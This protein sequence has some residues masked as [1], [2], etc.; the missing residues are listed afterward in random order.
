MDMKK[1]NIIVAILVVINTI[2]IVGIVADHQGLFS[3]N[4]LQLQM[5]NKHTVYI[6][7]GNNSN[8]TEYINKLESKIDSI[9][10]KNN[11]PGYTLFTT[12]GYMIIDEKP[13]KQKTLVYVFDRLTDDEIIPLLNDFKEYDSSLVLFVE[14]SS[15]SAGVYEK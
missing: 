12:E 5:H 7:L 4:D 10:E 3:N 15:A 11:V 1:I 2:A 8:N 13:V 9:C 6:G 14:K